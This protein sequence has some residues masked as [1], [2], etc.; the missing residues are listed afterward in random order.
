MSYL[1]TNELASVGFQSLGR[2]VLISSRAII[3]GPE[4]MELAD[5]VRVDDLCILS[6]R[7]R[8]HRNVHIAVMCNLAGGSHGILVEE[9]A[10]ISY[11]CQVFAQSDDYT[12]RALTGPTVPRKF[13][14]ETFAEVRIG[15]H[16]IVGA[17]SVILPGVHLQEGTAIGAGSVVTR[18]TEPWSIYVGA[19]ARRV[20]PRSRELLQLEA[21]YLRAEAEERG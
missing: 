17:S 8:L 14:G 7:V 10:G 6:G 16:C 5:N 20:R 9:F 4:Q 2:N 3:H 13:R 15:R 1:S 19:P 12:G 18:S 21:A 11:G